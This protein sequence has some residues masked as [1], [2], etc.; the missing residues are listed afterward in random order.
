MIK[1]IFISLIFF[2][3][4]AVFSQVPSQQQMQ[5]GINALNKQI[6][7]LENQIADAIK[8]GKNADLGKMISELEIFERTVKR[9]QKF[10]EKPCQWSKAKENHTLRTSM[11]R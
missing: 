1:I 9:H 4:T 7:D 2:S 6:A 3:P 8:N 10:S 5:S 11:D